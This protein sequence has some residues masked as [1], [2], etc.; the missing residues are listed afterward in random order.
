MEQSPS[1]EANRSS[2]SQEIPHIRWEQKVQYCIHKNPPPVPIL[3]QNNPV[4]V[5]HPTS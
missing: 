4:C 3:S 5:P 1:R 2:A